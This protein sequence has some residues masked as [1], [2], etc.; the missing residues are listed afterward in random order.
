MD[1]I[2]RIGAVREREV[3]RDPGLLTSHA[4]KGKKSC[5]RTSP[6]NLGNY[7]LQEANVVF[8]KLSVLLQRGD[9]SLIPPVH[10]ER[11]EVLQ[12]FFVCD[13]VMAE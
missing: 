6:L 11:L 2:Q 9:F 7:L 3:G 10:F 13:V 4:R 12:E 8:A 1:D 5:K